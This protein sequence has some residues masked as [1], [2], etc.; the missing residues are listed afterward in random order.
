MIAEAIFL[1]AFLLS[2]PRNCWLV[3]ILY[4]DLKPFVLTV[5]RL[6]CDAKALTLQAH[7]FLILFLIQSMLTFF[8][9]SSVFAE[10]SPETR[11]SYCVL[12]KLIYVVR[13][14]H[15]LHLHC[16]TNPSR[17]PYHGRAPSA[18]L[19]RTVRGMLPHKTARGSAALHHLMVSLFS[20]EFFSSFF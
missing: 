20:Q 12:T 3:S 6:Q 1:G 7:V 13:F 11:V 2:L 17:G 10:Q 4:V 14:H 18:I 19:H 9:S 8:F 15:F 5:S 16:N